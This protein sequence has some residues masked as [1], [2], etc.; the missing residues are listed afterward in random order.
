VPLLDQAVGETVVL[1]MDV[2]DKIEAAG[3][4]LPRKSSCPSDALSVTLLDT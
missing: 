3:V 4:L 2:Q 1:P